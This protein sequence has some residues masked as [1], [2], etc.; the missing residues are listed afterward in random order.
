MSVLGWPIKICISMDI[1]P[2][3]QAQILGCLFDT[4]IEGF[5]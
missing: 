3:S 2:L 1:L 5:E 4:V